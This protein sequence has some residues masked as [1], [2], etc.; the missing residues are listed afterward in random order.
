MVRGVKAKRRVTRLTCTDKKRKHKNL[1]FDKKK[2]SNSRAPSR[3]HVKTK[4][5]CFHFQHPQRGAIQFS[6]HTD[7]KCHV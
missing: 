7:S 3:P 6:T 2:K 4:A 5:D 1:D